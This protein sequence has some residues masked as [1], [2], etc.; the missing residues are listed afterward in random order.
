MS[1][2]QK[3][4]VILEGM[5]AISSFLGRSDATVLRIIRAEGLDEKRIV[6]KRGGIWVANMEKLNRWWRDG[7]DEW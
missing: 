7:V 6:F 5:K 1:K 3:K 4:A 2:Q